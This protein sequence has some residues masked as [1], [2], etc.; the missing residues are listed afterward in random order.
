[1][2]IRRIYS[3][4]LQ[5]EREG[6]DF[7]SANAERTGHAAAAGVFRRLAAEEERHITYVQGLLAALDSGTP[8]AEPPADLAGE[9]LFARRAETELLDQTVIESMTPDVTVLR[10]AYL[11][12]RDIAEFYEN[13]AAQVEGDAREALSALAAWER[14]HEKMFK[15]LHDRVYEQYMQMP[16]G[17]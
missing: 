8:A 5:R 10:T 3:Y 14:G 4:A 15:T 12:E 7:F 13:A 17:G 1:M 11:I 2:D 6:Y 16:W 9:G